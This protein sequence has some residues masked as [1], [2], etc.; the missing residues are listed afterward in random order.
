MDKK[1]YF[2]NC[3][4]SEKKLQFSELL[5]EAWDKVATA[6]NEISVFKQQ[7]YFRYTL[8]QYLNIRLLFHL[9]QICISNT[10]KINPNIHF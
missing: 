5:T 9:D 7:E 6:Q 4:W 10:T 8:L 1:N 3:G 2:Y